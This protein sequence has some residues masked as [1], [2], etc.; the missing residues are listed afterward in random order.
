MPCH[1]SLLKSYMRDYDSF[2]LV[3]PKGVVFSMSSIISWYLHHPDTSDWA[4]LSHL[5][6]FVFFIEKLFLNFI[7]ISVCIHCEALIWY[8]IFSHITE[9]ED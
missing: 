9:Q 8:S 7:S 2:S 5:Y 4:F 3:C 1:I 6:K